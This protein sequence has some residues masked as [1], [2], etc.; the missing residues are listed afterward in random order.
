MINEI[1]NLKSIGLSKIPKSITKS[2]PKT[3]GPIII[4]I[5]HWA[6]AGLGELLCESLVA[7]IGLAPVP[8]ASA[9]LVRTTALHAFVLLGA[10]ELHTAGDMPVLLFQNPLMTYFFV[11]AD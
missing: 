11:F 5:I 10:A 4:H 8:L 1:K 2:E 9:A 3:G 6:Y 7:S